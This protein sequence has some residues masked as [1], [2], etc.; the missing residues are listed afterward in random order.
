MT[1]AQ[2][3]MELYNC[4]VELEIVVGQLVATAPK[5]VLTPELA[6]AMKLHKPGLLRILEAE[7]EYN[8]LHHRIFELVDAAEASDLYGADVTAA[9]QRAEAHALVEG[10]YWEASER[11]LSLLD[12]G[13]LT[14]SHWTD[15]EGTEKTGL[16]VS[17]WKC[18]PM[19]QI[20][21]KA[22]QRPTPAAIGRPAMPARADTR[23]PATAGAAGRPEPW[24]GAAG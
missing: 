14:V 21:K 19:G 4:G 23:E 11:L 20:G 16:N 7:A 13:K 17:A 24:P 1:P 2:L 12:E 8:R 5:G 22:P 15:K 9:Q 3:R 6:A 10:P 18:E